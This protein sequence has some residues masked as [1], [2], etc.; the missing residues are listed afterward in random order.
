MESLRT[1]EFYHSLLTERE[2][3]IFEMYCREE[4]TFEEIG[5]ELGVTESRASQLFTEIKKKISRAIEDSNLL[6]ALSSK[7]HSDEA[8]IFCRQI[9][10]DRIRRARN[11]FKS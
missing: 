7:I 2:F 4:Y 11:V 3:V 9:I 10:Q 6:C 1:I 5:I 8:R